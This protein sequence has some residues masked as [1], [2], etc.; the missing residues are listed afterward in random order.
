[1]KQNAQDV[2]ALMAP[3]LA[4][5]HEGANL[6][7]KLRQDSMKCFQVRKQ[8]QAHIIAF[9]PRITIFVAIMILVLTF[10]DVGT[11]LT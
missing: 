1:M 3:G 7:A 8:C 9:Y 5:A 10:L 6:P 2:V 4:N 11:L